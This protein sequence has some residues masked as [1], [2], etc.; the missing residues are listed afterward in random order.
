[1]KWC[2]IG[3]GI[4]IVHHGL[5]CLHGV[6]IFIYAMHNPFVCAC[7]IGHIMCVCVTLGTC[8]CGGVLLRPSAYKFS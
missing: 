8:V 3:D 2:M 1:M 7:I 5:A 4:E 6:H